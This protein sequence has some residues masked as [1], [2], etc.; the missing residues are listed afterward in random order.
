MNMN[1]P[2]NGLA[3]IK[4]W[5]SLHLS[6]A[7]MSE[8]ELRYGH[9]RAIVATSLKKDVGNIT[10]VDYQAVPLTGYWV[11][12]DARSEIY[13]NTCYFEDVCIIF[14]EHSELA[15]ANSGLL[16]QEFILL[17]GLSDRDV[18]EKTNRHLL[19]RSTVQQYISAD[20]E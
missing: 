8:Q 6:V 18:L 10:E 16:Q 3:V 20:E 1:Y 19:Y 9:G 14:D 12:R 2:P 7:P 13:W 5:I 15:F 4:R 17:H 11:I